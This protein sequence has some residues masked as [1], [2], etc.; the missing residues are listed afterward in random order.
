MDSTYEVKGKDAK[1]EEIRGDVLRYQR[2]LAHELRTDNQGG[3]TFVTGPGTVYLLQKGSSD[4]LAPPPQPGARPPAPAPADKEAEKTLTRVYFELR[5]FSTP[6][7]DKGRITK[8]YQNVQVYHLPAK[9]PDVPVDQEKLPKG[10]IYMNCGLLEVR[11]RPLPDGKNTQEMTGTDRV[12]FR[13]PEFYG[14]ADKV[15]YDEALDQVVF[16]GDKTPATIY[17]RKGGV[18]G[19]EYEEIKGKKI[20]YNRKTGVFLFDGGRVI[21]ISGLAPA[22]RSLAVA[23]LHTDRQ[24]EPVAR[25][26]AG[27]EFGGRAGAGAA[28]RAAQRQGGGHRA[29]RDLLLGEQ[30][31]GDG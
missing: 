21:S 18:Q 4:P 16:T 6:L 8:F 14:R 28:R 1:G 20:L 22:P 31:R 12:F 5:M 26:G 19:R 25:G 9:T 23:G 10:G 27:E 13:T 30:A 24:E 3:P 2:L 11:S 29:R 17:R 15:V 7:P